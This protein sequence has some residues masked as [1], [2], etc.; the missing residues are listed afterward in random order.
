MKP[1]AA[2]VV[3]EPLDPVRQQPAADVR[4]IARFAREFTEQPLLFRFAL[5]VERGG[6]DCDGIVVHPG[7]PGEHQQEEQDDRACPRGRFGPADQRAGLAQRPCE[8]PAQQQRAHQADARW[9]DIDGRTGLGALE[10][11]R[12]PHPRTGLTEPPTASTTAAA[13]MGPSAPAPSAP[14]RCCPSAA[15]SAMA[16]K[17]QL[18]A[19]TT[20]S[21]TSPGRVRPPLLAPMASVHP[22]VTSCP[23]DP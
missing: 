5:Q 16:G 20:A 19:A 13:V 3:D 2:L 8:H 9:R 17:A 18:T 4:D 12:A 22:I 6:V 7:E 11:E 1:T 10:S 14:T 23:D 15:T 21:S